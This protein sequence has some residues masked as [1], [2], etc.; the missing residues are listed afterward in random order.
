LMLP[1]KPP[2]M[3]LLLPPLQLPKLMLMLKQH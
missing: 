1:T 2:L 3:P